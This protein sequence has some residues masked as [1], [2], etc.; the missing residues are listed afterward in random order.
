M[1]AA[2]CW[3]SQ[4]PGLPSSCSSSATR[5]SSDSG[6][7]V[8]TDPGKLG[9]DL[10]ELLLEGGGRRLVSHRATMVAARAWRLVPA[11][12]VGTRAGGA[13]RRLQGIFTAP[14]HRRAQ[15]S[16]ATA[17]Q[18]RL[19]TNR[20]TFATPQPGPDGPPRGTVPA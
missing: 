17:P 20:H 14:R 2:R 19:W 5:F 12:A 11:D 10:L 3:S 13:R 15:H 9:A 8:I 1:R 18:R 16:S 4:K 6:S 7:K